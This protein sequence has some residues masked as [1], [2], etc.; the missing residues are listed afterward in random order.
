MDNYQLQRGRLELKSVNPTFA[1]AQ[2]YRG[3]TLNSEDIDVV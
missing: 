1:I 3:F 2:I